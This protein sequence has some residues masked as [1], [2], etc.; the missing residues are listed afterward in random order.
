[1]V[2]NVFLCFLEKMNKTKNKSEPLK[3]KF[4]IDSWLSELAFKMWLVKGKDN[5]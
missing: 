5:A 3:W 2:D 4:F 1:M